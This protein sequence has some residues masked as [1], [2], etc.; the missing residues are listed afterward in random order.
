MLASVGTEVV[1][2]DFDGDLR[3]AVVVLHLADLDAAPA[4]L[5]RL[6]E[7]TRAIAILPRASLPAFV[8]IMQASERVAGML[9]AEEL[10]GD[11]LCAM[12]Q[13]VL[14]RGGFGLD[15]LLAAGDIHRVVVASYPEKLACIAQITELATRV[16]VRRKYREAIEHCVDELLMNALYDAPV[17]AAGRPLREQLPPTKIVLEG[18]RR[19]LVQYACDGTRFFIA[20]RDAFGRL[21]RETVLRYLDKCLHSEQQI[22]KPREGG[23]AGLG[24]YM[25]AS[26]SSQ[27]YFRVQPG[28]LTEATCIFD[29]KAPRQTLEGFGFVQERAAPARRRVRPAVVVLL[30]A[31]AL[32]LALIAIEAHARPAG[33][34]AHATGTS[35][36]PSIDRFASLAHLPESA[37]TQR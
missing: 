36:H 19:V 32:V 7:A 37:G 14:D 23:G 31:I 22:D 29:L 25:I 16:G 1:V 30:V 2:R 35:D 11:D 24:L 9:A 28:A 26:S 3:A 34:R 33:K 4:L 21:E 6:P 17:D 12:V 8:A 13:R 18:D 27:L 10:D 15:Q 20:V 5:A